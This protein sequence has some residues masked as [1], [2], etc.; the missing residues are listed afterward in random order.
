MPQ[1]PAKI[2]GKA[3]CFRPTSDVYC[4]RHI[5]ETNNAQ[6]RYDRTRGTTAERGYGARWQRAARRYLRQNPLCVQCQ[7]RGRVKQ[8]AEVDHKTPH[9]NDQE[10]FWDEDNW[11]ALCKPCHT[12]KTRREQ[13]ANSGKA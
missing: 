10:L 13:K 8:S 3:G 11:Q 12:R 6:R 4:E 1:R 9:E 7:T 2:C 5:D